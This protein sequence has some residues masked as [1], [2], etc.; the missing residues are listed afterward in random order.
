MTVRV[1]PLENGFYV[2]DTGEGIDPEEHDTVFEHGYTT[3]YSGSGTGLTIVSRI[4]QAH[5]WTVSLTETNEDG[6]R[7]EFRGKTDDM[8]SV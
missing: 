1:G 5:N 6:A 3:G 8:T 7:F 4:A 2:E